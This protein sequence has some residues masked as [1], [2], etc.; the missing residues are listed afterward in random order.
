MRHDNGFVALLQMNGNQIVSNLAVADPGSQWHP[1]APGDYDGDG[2]SDTLVVNDNG[3]VALWEMTGAHIDSNLG[4]ATIG[5]DWKIVP[6][7]YE[8]L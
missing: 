4:V 6:P 3:F 1:T 5:T 7:S 2:L 8:L